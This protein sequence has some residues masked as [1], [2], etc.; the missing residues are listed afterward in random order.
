MGMIRILIAGTMAFAANLLVWALWSGFRSY[1]PP[2]SVYSVAI[3]RP[4]A[5]V[6]FTIGGLWILFGIFLLYLPELLRHAAGR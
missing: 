2:G 3:L 6:C 4:Y 1:G 5:P